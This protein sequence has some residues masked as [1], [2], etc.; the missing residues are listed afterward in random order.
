LLDDLVKNL[1]RV[2]GS[3]IHDRTS[4]LSALLRDGI[5]IRECLTQPLPRPMHQHADRA[6]GD[7]EVLANLGL[8]HLLDALQPERLGLLARQARDLAPHAFH[9]LVP[10]GF[11]VRSPRRRAEDGG[12]VDGNDAAGF[13]SPLSETIERPSNRKPAKE[14]RP[15]HDCLGRRTGDDLGKDVLKAVERLGM[16]PED[17]VHS[18]PDERTVL[19]TNLW[20]IVHPGVPDWNGI[21]VT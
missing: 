21:N 4:F 10:F 15:A 12:V 14:R 5:E 19:F 17:P 18:S 20:P 13:G 9:E 1:I 6:S 8:T 7:T 3:T 11:N 2:K 16:I